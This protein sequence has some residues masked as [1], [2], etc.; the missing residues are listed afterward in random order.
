MKIPGGDNPIIDDRKLRSYCLDP[1]H[2]QGIHKARLFET[3]VGIT[4]AN[5]SVL[6]DALLIAAKSDQAIE[7]K[8]DQYGD[9]YSV[10]FEFAGPKGNA[11][12][13]AV[14]MVHRGESRPRLITCYIL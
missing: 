14:W 4:L 13:R 12:I 11:L 1:T 9:R 5:R 8:S 3:I 7:G 2:P 10:D 6:L